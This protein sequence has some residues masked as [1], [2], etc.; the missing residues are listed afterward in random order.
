MR[1]VVLF[2]GF[3]CAQAMR[4]AETRTNAELP[5]SITGDAGND[6]QAVVQD[7]FRKDGCLGLICGV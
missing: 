4:R 1:S 7:D 6:A 5:I 3:G 2:F